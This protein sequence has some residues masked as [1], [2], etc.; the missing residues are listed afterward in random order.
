MSRVMYYIVER[1]GR[2]DDVQGSRV[3]QVLPNQFLH[4]EVAQEM[5]DEL[6]LRHAPVAQFTKS[7]LQRF[8]VHAIHAGLLR[9]YIESRKEADRYE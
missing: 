6:N 5:A 7:T 9:E 3:K 4:P 2:R 1:E 8:E